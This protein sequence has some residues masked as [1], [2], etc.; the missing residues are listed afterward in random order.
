MSSFFDFFT[1]NDTASYATTKSTHRKS[2]KILQEIMIKCGSEQ[3]LETDYNFFGKMNIHSWKG[4][5][6]G[7]PTPE[8]IVEMHNLFV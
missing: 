1:F 7:R 3:E 4:K 6:A 8:W 5:I 2:L